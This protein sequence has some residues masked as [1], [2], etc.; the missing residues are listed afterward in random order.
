MSGTSPPLAEL[1]RWLAE[2]PEPF[3]AEPQGFAGGRIVVNAVVADLF[4][5][6][7][8]EQ[9]DEAWLA[10]FAPENSSK[11]ERNRLRFVLAACHLLWHP[12]LRTGIADRAGLSK[13]LVQDMAVMASVV[14]A[15]ELV[16]D[17]ERREELIRRA[18]RALG[19]LLP[20]EGQKESEDRLVQ[21]DSL[22]RHRLLR[23]AAKKEERAREVREMMARRAA[24][25]AAAK[26][27]RE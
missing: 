1:L 4:E 16:T 15:D 6:I 20:G 5:S 27:S 3:H 12:A 13:L 21:L 8:G 18:L 22:E 2:M 7:I 19:V 10:V 9:P 17:I 24:E 26:V 25:E 11:F 23:E 14:S